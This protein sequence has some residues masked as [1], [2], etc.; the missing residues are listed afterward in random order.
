MK[1]RR[2][3]MKLQTHVGEVRV[4]IKR[5]VVHEDGDECHAQ[6]IEGTPPIIEVEQNDNVVVM[7]KGVFY[8]C[9]H[10]CHE[11]ISHTEWTRV[12]GDI[13]WEK[14]E[15]REEEN[16]MFMETK[17]FDLLKRNGLLR[18]PKPPKLG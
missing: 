2:L 12:Y 11:G 6:Y 15:E 1:G 9:I 3:W 8:E 4:F 5:K 10:N 18:F 17:L 14:M 13:E 7:E 16:A